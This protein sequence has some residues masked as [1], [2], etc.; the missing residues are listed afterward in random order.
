M[1]C[2]TYLLSSGLIEALLPYLKIDIQEPVGDNLKIVV[3][4]RQSTMLHTPMDTKI[5]WTRR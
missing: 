5:Y 2:T 4:F 1:V 3:I